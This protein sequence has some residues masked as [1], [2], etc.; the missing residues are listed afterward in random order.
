MNEVR[1][2]LFDLKL[3][4]KKVFS[5][6]IYRVDI[7][8]YV[9]YNHELFEGLCIAIDISLLI[10][11]ETNFNI[12]EIPQLFPKFNVNNAI[13]FGASEKSS[14]WWRP[15]DWVGGRMAYLDWLI[16]E[17]KDDKEDLRKL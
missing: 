5:R 9:K 15:D 7:L 16:E 10:N 17:Y 1:K 13:P 6:P 4:Y 8:E 12:Q 3:R 11:L 2:K 14:W